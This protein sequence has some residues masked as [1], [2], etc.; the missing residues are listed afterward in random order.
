MERKYGKWF[1]EKIGG[2]ELQEL[3]DWLNS[4]ADFDKHAK[5]SNGSY[6]TDFGCGYQKAIGNV[7]EK[8]KLEWKQ[9]DKR[10]KTGYKIIIN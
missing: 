9:F 5:A 1:P 6:L 8:L 3:A 2:K 7:V 10:T 4:W